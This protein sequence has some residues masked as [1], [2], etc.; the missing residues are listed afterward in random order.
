MRLMYGLRRYLTNR[1]KRAL[2]F[3]N[4]YRAALASHALCRVRT[5]GVFHVR[6]VSPGA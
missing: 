3:E 5:L 6:A 1:T 4:K 2:L